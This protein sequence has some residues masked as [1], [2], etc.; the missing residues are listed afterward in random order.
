MQTEGHN[1]NEQQPGK[2]GDCHPATYYAGWTAVAIGAS[3]GGL[4]LLCSILLL[5][6]RWI[7]PPFTAFTLQEDWQELEAERYNLRGWWVPRNE[8]PEHLKWA[9]IAGEDQRFYEHRGFDLE[10]IQDA[11]QERRESGR[12][13][14]ASTIS[15]QVAKNLF[16]WPSRS[17]FRKAIE[18]GLTVLI[19]FFWP[20]ERILEVYL[21]TAEFGPGL[22][23]VGKASHDLF[24]RSAAELAPDMSARLAAVLP[25]PRRMRVE[26]PSPY[27]IERSGWIL[28]Q[29]AQL[30][31]QSHR[32]DHQRGSDSGDVV[33]PDYPHGEELSGSDEDP[34]V[35][36]DRLRGEVNERSDDYWEDVPDSLLLLPEM[37]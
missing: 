24:N 27:T 28:R 2:A 25:S 22:F 17:W 19:E 36:S 33:E 20:K 23:G 13:R 7:D 10:S 4:L 29:I 18:A 35:P 8:L 5:S 1:H 15:Q 3:I 30:T 14:G 16:L 12:V 37:E 32:N 11:F 34:G 31:G 26:P 21:N 9:V 6:L